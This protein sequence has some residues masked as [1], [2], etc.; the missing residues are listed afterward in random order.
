MGR[1][2]LKNPHL[3]T[4]AILFAVF[5]GAVIFISIKYGPAITRLMSQPEKFRTFIEAYGPLSA[6]VY[7][8][9]VALHI[10]IAVIPGE[11][12]Q[13]AGGYAFGTAAGTF[14]SVVGTLVGTVIVFFAT[15][16][17]GYSLVEAFVSPKSLERFDFLI[18]DPK[19]EIAMFVLFLVPGIPKDTLVYISGLT[20]IKPLRFLTICMIARFPGLLGS[21]YI[22]AHIHKK[23]Y[24]PVWILS[25][26]ALVLFAVGVCARGRIVDWLHRLRKGK[27]ETG[28]PPEERPSD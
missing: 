2:K 19:S 21:A 9:I 10:I 24:L 28:V 27:P 4:H 12:V 3:V 6:L 18:N 8:L 7:I 13:I 25:G 17:A 26:V 20:P 5:L 23:D 11:I 14:Y 1:G 16:L 15:R 22:G